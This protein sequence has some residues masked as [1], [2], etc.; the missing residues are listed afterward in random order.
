MD[1]GLVMF[2]TDETIDPASLARLAEDAGFESLFFPEHTHIPVSRQTPW[3]GGEELPRRYA[4]TLDLFVALTAAA[5]ATR[6]LRVGSGVC[7][8]VERDPIVTAKEVATLDLLSGGRVD[9]GVGA[10]WN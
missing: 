3:P 10:G 2:A 7:L 9:F 5:S 4:R 8:V 6:S 1:F